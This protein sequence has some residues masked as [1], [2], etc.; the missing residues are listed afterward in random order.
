MR[1]PG[2]LKGMYERFEVLHE[3]Y[4]PDWRVGQLILNFLSWYINE[5][6]TDTFYVEDKDFMSK[7]DRYFEMTFGA[8]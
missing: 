7:V 2:R 8:K 6:H 3:L 4:C 1:D 5:Y